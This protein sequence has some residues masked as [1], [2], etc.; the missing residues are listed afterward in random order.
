MKG[1]YTRLLFAMLLTL[2]CMIYAQE[3]PGF[4]NLKHSWRFQDG[5]AND[6]IGDAHGTAIGSGLF[7]GGDFI[8]IDTGQYI[9]LP[10][11]K[12]NINTYSEISLESWFTPTAGKNTTFHMLCY[13]GNSVNG[14]GS[15][16]YFI[17]PARL[18]DSCRT[19]ISCGNEATPYLSESFVQTAEID[20]GQQ[21]HIVS[22]LNATEIGMYLDGVLIGKGQLSGANSIANL[23]NNYAW[24]C[25]GG[26]TGDPSW[27][28]KIHEFNIYDKVLTFAEVQFQ[29]ARGPATVTYNDDKLI[30]NGHNLSQNFPNPFSQ[31]T[32]ISYTVPKTGHVQLSVHDLLGQEVITL[33]DALQNAGSYSTAFSREGLNSGVFYYQLKVNDQTITKRMIIL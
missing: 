29:F 15:D 20:D 12:I 18:Q 17:Q 33:V 14:A 1:Q 23:S 4:S 24:L 27:V 5:T 26:Y 9:I 19:A 7:A 22:T 8:A 25:K 30:L 2:S 10:A 31:S 21:H 3:D 28:G 16:G 6:C 32:N 13:F 11:D